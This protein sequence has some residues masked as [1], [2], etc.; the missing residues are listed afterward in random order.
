[1]LDG[2]SL[3]D[4]AAGRD[5]RWPAGRA[6]PLEL[7]TAGKP[8]DPFTPCSYAGVRTLG[9]VYLRHTSAAGADRAC[10]PVDEAEHYDLAADPFQLAN[11]LFAPAPGEEAEAAMLAARAERLSACAGIRGRDPRRPGR[12]FCE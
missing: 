9:E 4:L 3:A 11:L 1:V 2:R 6:I 5:G 10:A 12:A 8:A 7:D